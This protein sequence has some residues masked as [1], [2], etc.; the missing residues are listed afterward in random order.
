MAIRELNTAE[1]STVSGGANLV[2][3]VTG[4][5]AGVLTAPV[6]TNLLAAAGKLLNRLLPFW[7]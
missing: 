3:G 7:L 5:L 1:V 6:A 4:L 2:T